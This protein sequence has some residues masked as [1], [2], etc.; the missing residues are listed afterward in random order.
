[1]MSEAKKVIEVA[2]M[3]IKNADFDIK[4]ATAKNS[5]C[6]VYKKELEV[7][8]FDDR[9]LY[10]YTPEDGERETGVYTYNEKNINKVIKSIK[11]KFFA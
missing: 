3:L 4:S 11:E 6:L 1:M 2:K 7:K 8:I 10:L 5:I 9:I